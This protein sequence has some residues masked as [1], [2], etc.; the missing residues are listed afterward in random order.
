MSARSLQPQDSPQHLPKW[1]RQAVRLQALT[2]REAHLIQGY[3]MTTPPGSVSL[4]PLAMQEAV[5]RLWLLE[6]WSPSLLLQ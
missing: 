4:L 1:L 5:N 3:S 2:I 6:A